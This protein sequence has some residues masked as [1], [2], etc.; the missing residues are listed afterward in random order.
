MTQIKLED[1]EG[2]LQAERALRR[3]CRRTKDHDDCD[4]FKAWKRESNVFETLECDSEPG[5]QADI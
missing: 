2:L 5:E 3:I 1:T 4:L